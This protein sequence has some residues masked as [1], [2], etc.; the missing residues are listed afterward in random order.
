MPAWRTALCT[1]LVAIAVLTLPAQVAWASPGWSSRPRWRLPQVRERPCA[2]G[3]DLGDRRVA[4]R[5]RVQCA[6]D[7]PAAESP[8]RVAQSPPWVLLGFQAG[9]PAA[10]AHVAQRPE[11]S[12]PAATRVGRESAPPPGTWPD[13]T[14]IARLDERSCHAYLERSSVAFTIVRREEAPEVEQPIRLTGPIGGVTFAIPWSKDPSSDVHAIWDC[15]LAAAMIP[16]ATW[17]FTQGVR[18]V[19]YFSVLRRGS[20][21]RQRPRSQ[22]NVGLAIDVL[23]VLVDGQPTRWNVEDHYPVGFLSG[24]PGRSDRL[25]DPAAH[26]WT[27]AVCHAS[28]AAWFHTIL[29]PDHDHAHRNHLHLDLDLRQTA[30]ADPFVSFAGK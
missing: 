2:H 10:P 25:G 28:T 13:A 26:L 23:A 16:L 21:A 3:W 7:S 19:H 8:R 4:R 24:C 20:M 12:P 9:Q 30:P 22:H 17:L 5:D 27:T 11:A 18:E 14:A 1:R 29:T 6:H 15:R